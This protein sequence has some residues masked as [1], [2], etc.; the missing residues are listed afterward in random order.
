MRFRNGDKSRLLAIEMGFQER[1]KKLEEER[2][3]RLAVEFDLLMRRLNL[4]RP[5][6]GSNTLTSNSERVTHAGSI[7][8]KA[9][10]R[11]V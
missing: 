2:Q 7:A 1:D 4:P 8:P 9:V 5:P 6:Y 10:I 11:K 3:D